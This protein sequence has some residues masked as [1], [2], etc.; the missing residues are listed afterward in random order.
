MGRLPS[1]FRKANRTTRAFREMLSRLPKE[2][3]EAVIDAALLFH[4]NPAAK[5][6]R[7]HAL[8]DKSK[9]SHKPGSY[10]VS[11]TMLYRAIYF[12]VDGINVWYWVGTHDQYDKF[13]GGKS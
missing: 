10:S 6:L 3:F 9:A 13:T 5:S 11:I 4:S 1:S 8:L 7:H 12:K 2:V